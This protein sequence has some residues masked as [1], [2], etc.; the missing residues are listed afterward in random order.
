MTTQ[1]EALLARL[2]ALH[3]AATAGE[4]VLGEKE[5]VGYVYDE[6]DYELANVVSN[7]FEADA[8]WIAESKNAYPALAQAFREALAREARL[9]EAAQMVVQAFE[10]GID[11]ETTVRD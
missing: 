6:A 7:N 3:A 2:D 11:G 9:R 10:R 8:Q 4:W 1:H 5:E